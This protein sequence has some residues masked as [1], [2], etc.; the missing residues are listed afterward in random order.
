M[1]AVLVFL[2]SSP[3]RK[4]GFR[5]VG[6]GGRGHPFFF[7]TLYYL[8]TILRKIKGI[9]SWQVVKCPGHP[10]PSFLD[11]PLASKLSIFQMASEASHESSNFFPFVCYPR[12]TSSDC[13]RRELARRLLQSR[14]KSLFQNQAVSTHLTGKQYI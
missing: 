7:E 4:G 14:R 10:F 3:V 13:A 2:Q 1:A 8:Y 11:P 6:R 9:Y 12:V 5:G